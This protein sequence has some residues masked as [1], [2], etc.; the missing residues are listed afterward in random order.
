VETLAKRLL[1]RGT[2][3]AHGH[4]LLG[5]SLWRLLSFS[6]VLLGHISLYGWLWRGLG[7][8][9]CPHHLLHLSKKAHETQF[10]GLRGQSYFELFLRDKSAAS[11]PM[12]GR[13]S[14]VCSHFSN[15]YCRACQLSAVAFHIR[16]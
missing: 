4:T 13:K 7:S 3:R 2:F 5:A 10:L 16:S 12:D 1:A 6:V 14:M 8:Q 15:G 9:L 11:V